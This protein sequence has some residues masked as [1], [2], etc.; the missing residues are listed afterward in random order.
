MV[1]VIGGSTRLFSTE[2]SGFIA[3]VVFSSL[4]SLAKLPDQSDDIERC[5]DYFLYISTSLILF[6][7]FQQSLLCFLEQITH[8]KKV[9]KNIKVTGIVTIST[10]DIVYMFTFVFSEITRIISVIVSA[11]TLDSE[12]I[13]SIDLLRCNEVALYSEDKE[14]FQHGDCTPKLK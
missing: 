11:T 5:F 14:H 1:V 10:I 2:L 3:V 8:T 13:I 12:H 7:F 9:A 4:I 6:L